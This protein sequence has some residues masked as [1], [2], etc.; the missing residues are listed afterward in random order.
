[1]CVCV[2]VWGDLG[3][4]CHDNNYYIN[5]VINCSPYVFP[6]INCH[7]KHR[8]TDST[9]TLY[10]KPYGIEY[11]YKRGY[12]NVHDSAKSSIVSLLRCTMKR[13]FKNLINS[14]GLGC[15]NIFNFWSPR[16]GFILLNEIIRRFLQSPRFE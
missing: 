15:I 1:M 8:L 2:W 6:L 10:L 5:I 12:K 7:R 13:F 4:F 11:I 3:I 14:Y 9:T 16:K